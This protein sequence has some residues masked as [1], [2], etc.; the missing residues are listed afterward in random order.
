[1]TATNV[2]YF[3]TGF[4][5]GLFIMGVLSVMIIDNIKGYY[6]VD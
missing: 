4:L 1:M 5:A 3:I 2:I 6:Y